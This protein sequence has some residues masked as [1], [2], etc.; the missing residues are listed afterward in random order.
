MRVLKAATI[1]ACLVA[2]SLIAGA[3]S[4][5]QVGPP[6]GDVRSLTADPRD[7]R[8]LYLGTS[9]GHVFGSK[10]G[11][12]RWH[13]LGRVSTPD[14]VV[15]TLM[16][17]RRDSDVIFAGTWPLSGGK[18]GAWRSTDRGQT[19]KP[20]G[21]AGQ[22]VR[23]ITQAPSDLGTLYAGTL[24]G[25]YRSRD[26]GKNWERITPAGH[27]DLR[28]F[29]SLAVDP[30]DPAAIYAGTYHLAWKTSDA[31][32]NW[33]PIHAGM[34]DDSDVMSLVLDRN[35]PDRIFATACSGMYRSSERGERW[36]KIQGIPFSARRTHFI[37]QDPT[38]PRVFYAGTTQGLWK[39]EDDSLTWK[40]VT[41]ADWSIIGLVSDPKRP[42]RLVIG[43]ERRGIVV[44]E[45]GGATYRAS[46]E[47]FDHQ[48]TF[49]FA[50]DREHPQRMLVVLTNAAEAVRATD[51]GGRTW[52]TLGPGLKPE[53]T[54]HVYA[55]PG[56]PAAAGK[57]ATST[58]WWASLERGGLLRYDNKTGK[59]LSAGLMGSPATPAPKPAKGKKAPATRSTGAAA[60]KARVFDLEFTATA[61]Y[62][63]TDRGLHVSRD[64][65]NTWAAL[66]VGGSKNAQAF[67]V[68]VAPEGQISVLTAESLSLSADAGKTWQRRNLPGGAR[69]DLR[70]EQ[71]GGTLMLASENGLY[72]TH[73]NG[74]IWQQADIPGRRIEGFVAVE[75]TLLVSTER[76]LH[77]SHDGGRKWS[78]VP[79]EEAQG[80]FP[81][82]HRIGETETVLA[83][84]STEGLQTVSLPVQVGR[85]RDRRAGEGTR[86]AAPRQQQD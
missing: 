38:N 86:A 82:L 58:E 63:A 46:N 75:E 8:V 54:H 85:N 11:G 4:W 33:S 79:D 67:S 12:V 71:A 48:Q 2:C 78:R 17:D 31:G 10:D 34:I 37:H 57:A 83:A 64:R 5:Q 69:G 65:G 74:E 27:I 30:R 80:R 28:N 62:A 84:S 3:Q 19:W 66:A 20:A 47:G 25:I 59:W 55:A 7:A 49:L 42:G 32:R 21:L 13:Q 14:T 61:W 60:F 1:L 45:D 81:Y 15:F 70:L 29:D 56:A 76:G 39:S 18:G 44:S 51:D 53:L 50:M 52:R 6:G 22:T 72:L 77:I 43:L 35:N 16:V 68:R 73:D 9:D 26:D 36:S 41:S 23:A 40:R 24:D